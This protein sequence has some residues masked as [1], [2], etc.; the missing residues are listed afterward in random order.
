MHIK[1]ALA[2]ATSL[3]PPGV[4]LMAATS[5]EDMQASLLNL[6]E[7]AETIRTK[8]KEEDRELSDDEVDEILNL[9][10]Q[11]EALEKRI[12]ALTPKQPQ[13]AGRRTTPEVNNA[14]PNANANGNP[15]RVAVSAE[16]RVDNS[17]FGFRSFGAFAQA[18]R[19]AKVGHETEDVRKLYNTATT[20][21]NE[22]T[23]A[24]GGYLVP[25]SF[26]AEIWKKVQAE[27]NL[28]NRCAQLV[29]DGNSMTIPKD[30]STPWQTSGG[31]LVYW[32]GE[33][34]APTA[35]KPLFEMGQL[36]LSKLMALVPISEELLQDASGI[37]SWLRAKAPAKMAAKL[38]TAIVGGTGAGQPLGII[39][40][41]SAVGASVVQVSKETS[42]PADTIWFKNINK[43]WGRMYAPWRRNAVWLIN[44]DI[45]PS[46]AGMAFQATGASSDLPGTSAVP[47]YMPMNGLSQ[48]PY[49]P[50]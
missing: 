6:A 25:P 46:L 40:G 28:M 13:A 50:K 10:S 11:Q 41:Y 15:R 47:A 4:I 20:Y 22:G 24:D 35:S 1:D 14:A 18:V 44:Q 38:N 16:P 45:E 23:G 12:K 49:H 21:G 43:M 48:S 26:S 33:G 39:P 17:K 2:G 19:N 3:V 37:E 42:Q 5:I 36:R 7:Q 8:A 32:E 27:E 34:A 31:V 30:E 9:D 29:T